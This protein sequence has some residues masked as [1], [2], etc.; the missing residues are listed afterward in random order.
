[1]GF[2]HKFVKKLKM[3]KIIVSCICISILVFT[4]LAF[5]TGTPEGSPQ[6]DT[7]R[8]YTWEE[9]VKANAV[10]KKKFFIDV[11]TDWCGWCKTMDKE[12]FSKPEIA[13][14]LN[15]NY[16]PVKLNAEQKEDIIFGVDTFRFIKPETG[17]SRGVNQ[18]AYSLL[19]G[20]LGYPTVVYLTENYE[21]LMI[22]PGFKTPDDL[23]P[24]LK[25]AAE[26]HYKT[27]SWD[28]YLLSYKL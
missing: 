25:Y 8:W 16:Y 23:L 19:D 21:R 11:Y 24:Q 1:M 20:K 4:F 17:R 28:D 22:A 2:F 14:Y 18:L 9:A 26:N 5:T 27:I 10:V 13:A 3:K 15:A 6:E 12:T 7:V